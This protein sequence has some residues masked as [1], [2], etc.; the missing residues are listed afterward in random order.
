MQPVDLNEK[1]GFLTVEKKMVAA[2]K[3]GGEEN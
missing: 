3:T 2:E 1:N